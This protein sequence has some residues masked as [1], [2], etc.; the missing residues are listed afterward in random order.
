MAEPAVSRAKAASGDTE[1]FG[2][3][4]LVETHPPANQRLGSEGAIFDLSHDLRQ[5]LQIARAGLHQLI[6]AGPQIESLTL[7]GVGAATSGPPVKLRSLL[8]KL[9]PLYQVQDDKQL[10]ARLVETAASATGSQQVFALL[11]DRVTAEPD[12][13]SLRAQEA[14]LPHLAGTL[15]R[16]LEPLGNS[17]PGADMDSWL[18]MVPLCHES[19][20]EALLGFVS[21][22]RTDERAGRSLGMLRLLSLV[23]APFLAALRDM[24]RIRRRTDEL[25]T[26]LQIKSHLM[27]NTC[28]EFR[29]LLAAVRGYCKRILDGRTGAITDVQ[30]DQLTVVLRN[31]NKLLDLVN[32]SLP[33]VA[34][35]QLRVESFDLREI[36][37]GALQRA[38]RHLSE[39]SI[40]IREEIPSATFTVAADKGRLAVAFEL[41]LVGAIQCAAPGG[42]IT[43]QFLRGANGEVTVRLLAAGAGL[44]AHVLDGLFDHGGESIPSASPPDGQRI[45]GLSFVHDMIWLHGGRIAVMSSEEEGTVFVFTLPPPP[46]LRQDVHNAGNSDG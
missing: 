18:W 42:E 4:L 29:S 15:A 31:T 9:P 35:H 46:Q 33:F 45:S 14:C 44:P 10:L 32:H 11:C 40:R 6:I 28:H 13:A 25:E 39:K 27:S 41:V 5:A 23:S 34:E 3:V 22:D 2:R 17:A 20:L 30:R 16:Y 36:W 8:S 38:Q 21:W 7:D 24:E 12:L 43:A 26:V 1:K 37:R 19:R